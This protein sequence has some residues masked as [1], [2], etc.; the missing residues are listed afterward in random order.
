MLVF[1][2]GFVLFVM[3]GGLVVLRWPRVAW[4]HV[5]AVLWGAGIEFL[6]GI[7]PLT[8]LE[9]HW[10]GLGGDL[11]YHGGFIDHYVAAML[12]PAG[13]TR[14]MQ[15]MIGALVLGLNGAIYGWM[16][17]RRPSGKM[18]GDSFFDPRPRARHRRQ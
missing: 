3:L 7:C 8:P 12:Y 15:I 17:W 1:H 9:N 6:G 13:L 2:A 5:P 16:L 4:L 11:G 18:A 14:P 10:R